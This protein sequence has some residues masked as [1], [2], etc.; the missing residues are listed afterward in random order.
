MAAKPKFTVDLTAL[1]A[2]AWLMLRL[3]NLEK[4][5]SSIV[6]GK[7]TLEELH[8][9]CGAIRFALFQYR[10]ESTRTPGRFDEVAEELIKITADVLSCAANLNP[11]T[12]IENNLERPIDAIGHHLQDFK[13]CLTASRQAQANL[14]RE[15]EEETQRLAQLVHA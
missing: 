2:Q 10:A 5:Y 11:Q 3:G 14:L 12:V 15:R 8:S 4:P 6:S 7:I 1:P 13:K 9:Y